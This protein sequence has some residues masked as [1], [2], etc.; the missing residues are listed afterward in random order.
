MPPGRRALLGLVH[1]IVLGGSIEADEEARLRS[2][3][4]L[5]GFRG[6][7]RAHLLRRMM[8]AGLAQGD[9]R[10][11]FP[12]LDG[13]LT[14]ACSAGDGGVGWEILAHGTHEPHVVAFYRSF[15]RPGMH[16]ADVGANIGF[17]ALH[18]ATLVQP[19]GRV[20]AVEPDPGSAALLAFSLSLD[21]SLPVE[22]VRA[23]LSDAAGSLVLSDLGNPGNS[24]A[25]FTHPDRAHLERLVHGPR[26]AFSTTPALR[27]DDRFSDLP[28]SLVKI[29]IEGYE[30]R[31]LRGMEG[32]I[33]RHRPVILTEF[34]PWNLRD[35]GGTEPRDYLRWLLGRG[36]RGALLEEAGGP[37]APLTGEDDPRLDPARWPA[38]RHHVD[39]VF[40]PE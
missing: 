19:G 31:A 25:R 1:R 17:H 23:G 38:G 32:S 2:E 21:P 39:L 29:D 13:L 22:L 9:V 27:W 20:V 18:A 5:S 16:V 30:P 8:R 26:P 37:P 12:A 33:A 10:L 14:L 28:L 24:G 34:A 6:A 36:Y 35:V 40:T 15:L 11:V 7:A 3:L 4:Q